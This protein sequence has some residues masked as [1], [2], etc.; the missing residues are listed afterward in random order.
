MMAPSERRREAV[1]WEAARESVARLGQILSG[2]AERSP[3]RTREILDERARLLARPATAPRQEDELQLLVF[4]IGEEHFAF[5]SRCVLAVDR[6]LR[7]ALLPAA[8]PPLRGFAAWRGELLTLFDLGQLTGA[9]ATSRVEAPVVLVLGSERGAF[10]VLIDEIPRTET[11][12]PADVR[13]L[14]HGLGDGR[15]HLLGTT[16]GSAL[17]VDAAALIS[18]SIHPV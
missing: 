2:T 15:R 11:L 4:P 17:V 3:A 12:V 1:D 18:D 13:P 8:P 16:P 10:G 14:Q 6:S 9:A 7:P 5:E